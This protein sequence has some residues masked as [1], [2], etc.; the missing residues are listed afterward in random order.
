MLL[1]EQHTHRIE[2]ILQA[3]QLCYADMAIGTAT[4]ISSWCSWRRDAG[5]ETGRLLM[6]ELDPP[7]A[8]YLV[9]SLTKPFVA[10]LAVQLAAEGW[11]WLNEPVRRFLPAFSRGPL[12]TI[13][14]RHLLT[15]TSGLP[16]MLPENEHLRARHA[17]VLEFAEAVSRI[18]PA[19]QPGT[20]LSYCSM[21]FAVLEAV[22][23]GVVGRSLPQLLD[24][25]LVQPLGLRNSWLGLP[26]AE[27]PRMLEQTIAC[28]LPPSQ[29]A[30]SNWH[31]N[32]QY[33][34]TLGAPWGGLIS[35]TGDLG[36]L[37]GMM[38]RGGSSVEGAQVLSFGVVEA[39]VSNQT[40][41]IA[42]LGE[43]DRLRRP[44]GYGWRLNWLDH[45]GCFSDLLP[46][47]SFGHWGATGT[48]MWA[49][50][51]SGSWGVVLTNQPWER[52]QGAIQRLSNVLV[53]AGGVWREA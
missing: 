34:R 49:D 30:D 1:S 24:E 40:Q 11:F 17:G 50:R 9:A 42:G 25:L 41:Y 10:V 29:P 16:D 38:L 32:S 4:G 18:D 26:A 21:G 52:S 7:A 39:A 45:S 28:E 35:T 48:V 37:L 43:Q 46:A 3:S 23:R 22:I 20:S 19:F 14:L 13:T 15:H 12:R 27:A 31:W 51:R 36:E 33:W 47:D 2:R 44:W 8:H 5:A 6:G 53:D